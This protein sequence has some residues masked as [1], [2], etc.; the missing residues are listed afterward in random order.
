[1]SRLIAI[2]SH[3]SS[4]SPAKYQTGSEAPYDGQGCNIVLAGQTY[5]NSEMVIKYRA[6][7]E[8]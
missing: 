7:V 1:M 8:W 2:L 5:H 3:G 4:L 6:L